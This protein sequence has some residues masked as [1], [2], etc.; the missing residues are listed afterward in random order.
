MEPTAENNF[1]E[2]LHIDPRR[3]P[4]FRS[5]ETSASLHAAARPQQLTPKVRNQPLQLSKIPP[6]GPDAR[7]R[8]R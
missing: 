7:G 4:T 3:P 8:Q 6:R 5:A 2:P 1:G